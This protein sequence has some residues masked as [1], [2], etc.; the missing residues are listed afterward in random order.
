MKFDAPQN[1]NYAAVIV[2]VRAINTLPKRDR[3][4]G[5]PLLGLQA[6]TD[7]STQVGDLVVMFGAETQLSLEFA[8]ENNLHRHGNLNKDESK[9]GYLEDNR[10]VRAIQFAGNR[11]DALIMP[12]E[13][14]AYTGV[15]VADL[16]EGDTFDKLNG[17]DICNKYVVK[18][19]GE[20]KFQAKKERRVD[21]KFFP[22]HFDTANYWRNLDTLNSTDWITVTQKLHGTS[23][24]VGF[25]PVARKL[26]WLERLLLK[27]GVAELE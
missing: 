23:L 12:L 21:E 14:L 11:S 8:A 22:Q 3:I 4:F 20:P 13:S 27:I 26:N 2:Q 15:D 6:I 19:K 10:R 9:A 16:R 18:T 1:E 5:V 7:A 25:V 17:H 24:R